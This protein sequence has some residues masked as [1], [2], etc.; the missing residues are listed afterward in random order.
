MSAFQ[1]RCRATDRI[2]HFPG[3][4]TSVWT[5]G[6]SLPH[7]SLSLKIREGHQQL[8]AVTVNLSSTLPLPSLCPITSS[9]Y[10]FMFHLPTLTLWSAH[11]RVYVRVH[12]RVRGVYI[13]AGGQP[14]VLLLRHLLPHFLRQGPCWSN[15]PLG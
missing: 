11:M 9:S 1:E 15:S 12:V 14:Q 7:L 4:P 13:E 5:A 8:I 10:I 3:N 6:R 2:T